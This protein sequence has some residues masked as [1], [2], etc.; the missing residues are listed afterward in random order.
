[1][2]EKQNNGS[3]HNNNKCN[4]NASNIGHWS[5]RVSPRKTIECRKDISVKYLVSIFCFRLFFVH[6]FI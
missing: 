4:G 1:M 3:H 5:K 6:S 2:A